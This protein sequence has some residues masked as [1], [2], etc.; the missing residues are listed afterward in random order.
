MRLAEIKKIEQQSR[1]AV[2]IPLS[3]RRKDTTDKRVFGYDTEYT[4]KEILSFSLSFDYCGEPTSE[5][6]Y[7][8]KEKIS[9][10]DL[11]DAIKKINTK[12]GLKRAKTYYLVAHFTQADISRITDFDYKNLIENKHT[13]IMEVSNTYIGSLYPAKG[14]QL[15]VLDLFAFFK[16]SLEK[17]GDIL[18]FPKIKVDQYYKENMDIFLQ[19]FPKEYEAYANR[20]AEITL[21]AFQELD[22]L[23]DPYEV[24]PIEYPTA[25]ALALAIMRKKFM[26]FPSC[27][28]VE[29]GKDEGRKKKVY[30]DNWRI[31][32]QALKSYWGGHNEN[33]YYGTIMGR[34]LS[35][36]DVASL[37]PNSAKLQPLPNLNTQWVFIDRATKDWDT[38]EGFCTV[39]F[40]FPDGINYPSLPVYSNSYLCFPKSGI[41]HC[42][43][44]E[45]RVAKM[46]GAELKIIQGYGF[47]P[48]YDEKH[49]D[50]VKFFQHFTDKKDSIDK[51]A[52]PFNYQFVKLMMNSLIGK[53]VQRKQVTD[54]IEVSR[55]YGMGLNEMGSIVDPELRRLK[56]K[57]TKIHLGSGFSPEW[58]ALILGKSR[59]IMAELNHYNKPYMCVTDSMLIDHE[60]VRCKALE[61]LESVG[62][63]LECEVV[64]TTAF[65]MRLRTYWLIDDYARTLYDPVLDEFAQLSANPVKWI[66][67]KA[68]HGLGIKVS[69]KDFDT[70]V[71]RHVYYGEPL[72][73]KV[74][75]KR[76]C[77]F[78]ESYKRGLRWNSEIIQVSTPSYKPDQ[79][80]TILPTGWSVPFIEVD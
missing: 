48:T 1:N 70:A 15:K 19:K 32:V 75:K 35:Q 59:A 20:D 30:T 52:D 53:F 21:A 10:T 12:Y 45:M 37:Y 28:F 4:D 76:L 8:R 47:V 14:I 65:L 13:K 33:F 27:R 2:L 11:Y 50:L 16:T 36:Y 23:A 79:K 17:I 51:K 40:K 54:M 25:P 9:S 31:R 62:S 6:F 57:Y 68:V 26:H 44:S 43:I 72:P 29:V 73:V 69:D 66:A 24:S 49:H 41:S 42:T 3:K 38:L 67:K 22:A 39:E 46:Q 71:L 18:G 55:E 64:C 78:K 63:S 34:K 56:D 80:R 74:S 58:A 77:R 60:L 5:I 7:C 61:E